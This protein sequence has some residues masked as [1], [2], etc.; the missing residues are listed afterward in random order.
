MPICAR[1]GLPVLLTVAPGAGGS[2]ASR[3]LNAEAQRDLEA[4]LR[5]VGA[6]LPAA[7]PLAMH[8]YGGTP[9]FALGLMRA[10]PALHVSLCGSCTFSKSK[11]LRA[12]RLINR[13]TCAH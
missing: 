1:T 3:E 7:H 4:T 8:A 2:K 11:H 12:R 13:R 6:A 10:Y 9:E 5:G